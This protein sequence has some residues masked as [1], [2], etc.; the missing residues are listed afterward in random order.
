MFAVRQHRGGFRGVAFAFEVERNYR[1]GEKGHNTR[2]N[3]GETEGDEELEP[4]SLAQAFPVARAGELR[5]VDP[6]A[7]NRSED[8]EIEYE[9]QL[10]CDGNAGQLRRTDLAD[11]HVIQQIYRCSDH[12]LHDNRQN[13]H[14]NGAIKLPVAYKDITYAAKDAAEIRLLHVIHLSTE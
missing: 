13:K 1:F 10:I 9:Y 3:G 4:K 12:V 6:R 14:E 11:H 5:A 7:G 2:G 8:S